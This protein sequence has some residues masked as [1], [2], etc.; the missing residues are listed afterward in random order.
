MAKG[1]ESEASND[2]TGPHSLPLP[3]IQA[4]P[5]RNL[6]APR[7]SEPGGVDPPG[8]LDRRVRR[9]RQAQGAGLAAGHTWANRKVDATRARLPAQGPEQGRLVGLSAK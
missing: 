4:R 9:G 2:E 7:A 6:P 1:S 5:S 3:A 8:L